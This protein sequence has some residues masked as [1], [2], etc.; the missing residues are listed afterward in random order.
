MTRSVAFY[1]PQFHAIPENDAWWG[2]GFTDWTNVQAARPLFPGHQQ[3][4]RAGSLGYYDLLDPAVRQAQADLARQHAIS[5]FCYYHYWFEGKELL[6][7]PLDAVLSSGK[8]DFPFC[9]CWANE[10]WT[11]RWEGGDRQVLIRQT[12]SPSDDRRHIERLLPIF[13]DSRYLR[14]DGRP[15][16]LVWRASSLPGPN[17]TLSMWRDSARAAGVGELM[18]LRVESFRAERGDPRPLGFDAAVDFQPDWRQVGWGVARRLAAWTGRRVGLADLLTPPYTRVDYAAVAARAV[19]S[20][21]VGYP[22]FPCV[23]PGWDNSPRRKRGAIVVEGSTPALYR[24]WVE[25]VLSPAPELMFINAW[26]EWGEG[27]HLEPSAES[28]AAYL[29]AH[30]H[31]MRSA[32]K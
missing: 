15:V 23:M 21:N 1:L 27:C 12:Y 4:H 8:P 26:N 25:A 30:R 28:G 9:I 18:I 20:Q 13:A 24:E 31:A 22:R 19:A 3:P 6:E 17:R 2:A 16:F 7:R 14:L 29:E 5:G 32:K 10:S 11:R